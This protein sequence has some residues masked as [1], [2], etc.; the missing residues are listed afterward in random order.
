MDSWVQISDVLVAPA[1]VFQLSASEKP[2]KPIV[3]IL[4]HY[5]FVLKEFF[6]L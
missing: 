5:Y 3:T 6:S 2:Q 4:F 1:P